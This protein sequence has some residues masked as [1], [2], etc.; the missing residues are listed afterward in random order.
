MA[1]AARYWKQNFL[2]RERPTANAV[3]SISMG[4]MGGDGILWV[5]HTLLYALDAADK[6][7]T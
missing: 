2:F 4:G 7:G 1:D 6:F 3:R 5:T